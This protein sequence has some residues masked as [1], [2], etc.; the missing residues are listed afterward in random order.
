MV[1]GG[2]MNENENAVGEFIVTPLARSV[3]ALRCRPYSHAHIVWSRDGQGRFLSPR[4]AW[5]LE[6]KN[7]IL[8]HS[9][10]NVNDGGDGFAY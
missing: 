3:L 6:D 7:R 9:S 1:A 4:R 8:G 5:T 2:G 10:V